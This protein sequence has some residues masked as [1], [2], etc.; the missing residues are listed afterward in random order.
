LYKFNI[1]DE[2][3]TEIVTNIQP[4]VVPRNRYYNSYSS[5]VSS[6][7]SLEAGDEIS[8]KISDISYIRYTRNNY[9]GLNLI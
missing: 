3:E 1:L 2:A 8:V 5:F 4:H 6:L 9:F 7:V